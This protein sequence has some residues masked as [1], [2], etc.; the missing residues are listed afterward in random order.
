MKLQQLRFI[1]EV[2][3]QDLNLTKAASELYT[4][5]PGISKQIK[6]LER[7]P[8][9]VWDAKFARWMKYYK[10]LLQFIEREKNPNV[11]RN[12]H[13]ETMPDGEMLDLSYWLYK[14]RLRYRN[15][16][17]EQKR[18][19]KLNEVGVDWAGDFAP[20]KKKSRLN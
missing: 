1:C 12:K 16:T 8:Y 6:A 17:L 14:Q 3:K 19:D 18:I 15:R 5:Q 2:A 13:N 9:W 10:A 4:S 11:P 20:E 7:I